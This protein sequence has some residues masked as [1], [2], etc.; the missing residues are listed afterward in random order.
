M[1]PRR[2]APKKVVKFKGG[3]SG[4]YVAPEGT[5]GELINRYVKV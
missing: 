4:K 1:M 5:L 2:G 3:K